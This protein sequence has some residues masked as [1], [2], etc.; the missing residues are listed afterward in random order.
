[1]DIFWNNERCVPFN[2]KPWHGFVDKSMQNKRHKYY[3]ITSTTFSL[4]E[5]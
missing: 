1:M 5:K 3:N 2:H 4:P